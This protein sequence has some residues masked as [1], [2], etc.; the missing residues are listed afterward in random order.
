MHIVC[1]DS[2]QI[3]TRKPYFTPL[4]EIRSNPLSP[5]GSALALT[6]RLLLGAL[7]D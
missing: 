1:N 6:C 4:I 2:F 3:K 5:T 7:W